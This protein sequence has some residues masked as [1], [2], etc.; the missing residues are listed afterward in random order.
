V[1]PENRLVAR[2][3]EAEWERRLRELDQAQRE[4]ATRESQRP[5]ALRPADTERLRALG[6]DLR[7]VWTAPTTTA[8]DKKELLR[9]LL[10]DVVI[11]VERSEARAHLTLR[12]RGGTVTTREVSLPH[13]NPPRIRTDEDSLALIQRLAP[14]YPDAVIAGILNRQGRRTA[15]GERFTAPH[16]GNLRRYRSIPRCEPPAERSDG[17]D[18]KLVTIKKAAAILGVAPSTLHRWLIAGIIVGEQL[19]PGAPWRIRLTDEVR[20]RFVE[21]APPEYLP[22]LE[23]RLRLGVSRQTVLQRVKRGELDTLPVRRGRRQGLRTK[24]VTEHPELFHNLP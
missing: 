24:V 18:S 17:D 12:W 8:R 20:A 15:R 16:V 9:A 5:R 23:A 19:T 11:A 4:L 13:S 14:H 1:E 6:D 2:G 7:R 10:E 3:L 21:E 22:M